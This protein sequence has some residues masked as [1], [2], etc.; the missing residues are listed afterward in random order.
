MEWPYSSRVAAL[1]TEAGLTHVIHLQLKSGAIDAMYVTQGA[2]EYEFIL[3]RTRRAT[4][5]NWSG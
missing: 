2:N 3:Q 1:H 4:C 5:H